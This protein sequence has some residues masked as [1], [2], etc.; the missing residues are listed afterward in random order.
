M[1]HNGVTSGIHYLDNFLFVGPSESDEC[2][3][4]LSCAMATCNKPVASRKLAGPT[5]V[6]TF[7]GIEIDTVAGQLR[8]STEKLTRLN[9]GPSK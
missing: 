3:Q 1:Y 8:I 4:N 2:T 7:L 9:D 6:L 5:T